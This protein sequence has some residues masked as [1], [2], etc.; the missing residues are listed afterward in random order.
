MP[1]QRVPSGGAMMRSA[2]SKYR[3]RCVNDVGTARSRGD[4]LALTPTLPLRRPPRTPCGL[5]HPCGTHSPR[6][7]G[8]SVLERPALAVM[9]GIARPTAPAPHPIAPAPHPTAPAP[10]PT[11]PAP[12]PTAPA[13]HPT[14]PAP[15]PTAPAPHPTAPAPHPT[16]PAPHPTA[17]APHPTA[18]APHRTDPPPAYPT[19][20]A[21]HPTAPA[22]LK[23]Q[24]TP[25][26]G[27]R[28]GSCSTRS[29]FRANPGSQP[30]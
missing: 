19:A 28:P 17:P 8:A 5:L 13:P 18:P 4:V 26:A 21:P 2:S 25:R 16:A 24:E 1:T 15:H 7:E 11:A 22:S 9:A 6:T 12:H 23:P 3:F 30:A 14:A 20:P 29:S 27:R 10:H